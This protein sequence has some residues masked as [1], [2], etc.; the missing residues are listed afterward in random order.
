MTAGSYPDVEEV[1]IALLTPYGTTSIDTPADW[2]GVLPYHR[3]MVIGGLDDTLTDVS[4][5]VV[6]TFGA[7]VFAARDAAES[8]RQMLTAVG[9]RIVPGVGIL[10]RVTTQTKPHK[11]PWSTEASP[12][13]YTHAYRATARRN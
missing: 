10:D 13:R 5:V 3:I 4:Q 11:V 2:T 1:L 6:D 9:A 12:V 7:D 8:V